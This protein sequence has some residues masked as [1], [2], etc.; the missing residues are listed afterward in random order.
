MKSGFP[1]SNALHSDESSRRDRAGRMW[2]MRGKLGRRR[3]IDDQ[4]A[5][6]RP[7]DGEGVVCN[8]H[9]RISSIHASSRQV[10]CCLPMPGREAV[11]PDSVHPSGNLLFPRSGIMC[12]RYSVRKPDIR[13]VAFIVPAAG[14]ADP[15]FISGMTGTIVSSL[16]V[17]C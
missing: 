6:A 11:R 15:R 1:H 9:L 4:T 3:W 13:T 7:D 5:E 17:R 16:S 2:I 14:Y 12:C 10:W 8:H